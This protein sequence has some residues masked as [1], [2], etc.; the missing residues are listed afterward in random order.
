MKRSF[1]GTICP[2]C[3]LN[4]SAR[5]LYEGRKLNQLAAFLFRF[6]DGES[7]TKLRP[8]RYRIGDR[9]LLFRLD[10]VDASFVCSF[11]DDELKSSFNSESLVFCSSD[12]LSALLSR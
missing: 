4:S 11:R 12:D 9:L 2:K 6:F 10:D 8:R 5:T 7:V 1:D 3:F